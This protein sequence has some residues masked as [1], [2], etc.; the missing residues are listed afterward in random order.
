MVEKENQ[1]QMEVLQKIAYADKRVSKSQIKEININMVIDSHKVKNISLREA[2]IL[3]LALAKIVARRFK[4]LI[5]DCNHVIQ[6]LSK[7]TS[8]VVKSVRIPSSK[9]ITL[10]VENNLVLVDDGMADMDDQFVVPEL[11][12]TILNENPAFEADFG[13]LPSMEQVRNSAVLSSGVFGG[14]SNVSV[15]L[16]RRRVAEDGVTEIDETVFRGNLRN[17]ADILRKERRCS[18]EELTKQKL[19]IDPKV[20]AVFRKPEAGNMTIEVQREPSF[21]VEDINHPEFSFAPGGNATADSFVSAEL[22]DRHDSL[23]TGINLSLL[24]ETFKFGCVVEHLSVPEKASCFF[25]LLAL[26]A[27]GRI[28]V[29]QAEPFSEIECAQTGFCK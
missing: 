4:F 16:K 26:A 2:S 7:D 3:I 10:N 12:E 21:G 22:D 27:E 1:L 17:V 25:A 11:E 14:E 18:I 13:D 29:D 6:L 5:E 24:P 20:A 15:A 28:A 8:S 23:T 9:A 19:Q